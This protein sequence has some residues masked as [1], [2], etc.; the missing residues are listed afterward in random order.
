MIHP[1]QLS[2]GFESVS[3]AFTASPQILNLTLSETEADTWMYLGSLLALGSAEPL[4]CWAETRRWVE[5]SGGEDA[6]DAL[7]LIHDLQT[8]PEPDATEAGQI[9]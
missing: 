9:I 3:P 4:D 5:Y 7:D 2:L 1:D 8:R 6:L